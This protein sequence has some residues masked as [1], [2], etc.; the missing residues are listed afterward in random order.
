MS[1]RLGFGVVFALL[2]ACGDSGTTPFEDAG[3]SDARPLDARVADAGSDVLLPPDAGETDA[4]ADD[5]GPEPLGAPYPI[6]L[7]HGFFGFET[8]A[9]GEWD[10][11]DYF[12]GVPAHLETELG[13]TEVFTPAV[14]PFNG[15]E[16]RGEELLAHIEMILAET[17]RAKVNLIGH[18]QGCLLYTI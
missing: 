9:V 7:A 14:D 17:G 8:L 4:A 6:V 11:T 13:E 5:A 2:C 15:S 10:I 3:A 1:S 18:S 12:F 16:H